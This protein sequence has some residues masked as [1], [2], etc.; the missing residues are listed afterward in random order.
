METPSCITEKS[1]VPMLN[2]LYVTNAEFQECF[3]KIWACFYSK[4]RTNLEKAVQSYRNY[5]KV[6]Y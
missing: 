4:K 2:E 5:S 6:S 3:I 1:L